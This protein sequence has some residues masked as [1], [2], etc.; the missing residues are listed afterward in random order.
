MTNTLMEKSASRIKEVKIKAM[1]CHFVSV[2]LI[3][4]ELKYNLAKFL[5][6]NLLFIGKLYTLAE[7]IKRRS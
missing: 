5:G 2:I 7:K 1:K 4:I 3:N 6:E